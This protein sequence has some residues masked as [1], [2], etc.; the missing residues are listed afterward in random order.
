MKPVRIIV[1]GKG[2]SGKST[3]VAALAKFVVKKVRHVV[4]VD[5]DESNPGI[6]GKFGLNSLNQS[7]MDKLGGRR[8]V[9]GRRKN[10][11]SKTLQETVRSI[12]KKK[13]DENLSIVWVGKIRKAG[14]GCACPHGVITRQILSYPFKNGTFVVVDAE[15]GIEHFGR[16]IDNMVD[17][18]IFVVDPSHDSVK[19]CEEAKK[20]A[21]S[22]NVDF[23]VVLNKVNSEDVL[24]F[25]KN[26]LAKKDIDVKVTIPYDSKVFR[27]SMLGKDIEVEEAAES[28]KKLVSIIF[29]S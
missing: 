25:M 17:K 7:L 6:E 22:I 2:G 29:Q 21:D 19:I 9:F 28:I 10:T 27:S 23:V 11:S 20:L 13:E 3:I 8:R 18:I 26:E 24:T 4:V 15:A 14:S 16:G 1:A 12:M 5:A